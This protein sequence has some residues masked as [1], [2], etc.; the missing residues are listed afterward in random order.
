M[1]RWTLDEKWLSSLKPVPGISSTDYEYSGDRTAL[2]ALKSLPGASWV[3][4]KWLEFWL[5]FDRVRYMGSAVRVSEKQFPEVYAL[6]NRAA[7]L[8][9]M[10]RPPLFIVEAPYI[11]AYTLGTDDG[12]SFIL[13]TR[14]LLDVATDRELLFIIGHEMGHVKSQH[15]LYGT[16]AIFLANAGLFAGAA[17]PGIQLLA[18]PVRMALN[19]WFRRSEITCDRAGLVCC[20]DLAV[21]RRA[22]LLTGCGSRELADRIDLE[23]FAK[24]GV[25]ASNSYGKWGEMWASHPYLPKRIRA[26]ELFAEGHFYV[27]QVLRDKESRFLDNQDLDRAVGVVLGDDQPEL[28]KITESSDEGRLRVAAAL[29]GA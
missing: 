9:S 11:N 24:Q 16:M 18:L 19:A 22:L 27:R 21:A 17:I 8:L 12:G 15:V 3:F 1:P 26:A 20:Q 28:E 4:K 7:E 10:T 14:A 29:A 2:A 5:E 25:E 13:V 23:E 6:Q